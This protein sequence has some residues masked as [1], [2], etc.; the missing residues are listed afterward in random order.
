MSNE[1]K[2][3]DL[4]DVIQYIKEAKERGKSVAIRYQDGWVYGEIMGGIISEPIIL[5]AVNLNSLCQDLYDSLIAE[6]SEEIKPGWSSSWE[7]F[8]SL[9]NILIFFPQD[10]KW[11][12]QQMK[13]DSANGPKVPADQIY[14][15]EKKNG[16]LT[17]FKHNE[18]FAFYKNVHSFIVPKLSD[19]KRTIEEIEKS[20]IQMEF[21]MW[22]GQLELIDKLEETYNN[23]KNVQVETVIH[24]GDILDGESTATVEVTPEEAIKNQNE[25]ISEYFK[26]IAKYPNVKTI[27]P[28]INSVDT[29]FTF[30][31]SQVNE[32][33]SQMKVTH[34]LVPSIG[35]EL[36]PCFGFVASYNETDGKYYIPEYNDEEICDNIIGINVESMI[37]IK[38]I[39][40]KTIELGMSRL[41]S[42][43][44]AH[45]DWQRVISTTIGEVLI[46]YLPTFATEL[47]KRL[48]GINHFNNHYFSKLEVADS[49]ELSDDEYNSIVDKGIRYYNYLAEKENDPVREIQSEQLL[50]MRRKNKDSNN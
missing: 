22:K 34:I 23:L 36:Y 35:D 2:K 13:K 32:I 20:I 16:F 5:N 24:V 42:Y 40:Q 46:D 47:K 33:D 8:M 9:G 43:Y 30:N 1:N 15:L 7:Y 6:F 18:D 26:M 12:Y 19:D 49:L 39:S 31:R 3:N 44:F 48:N 38:V 27:S 41:Y 37:P 50:K 21:E 45:T 14:D 17:P 28:F 10:T 11:G 4:K 25:Q 29:D